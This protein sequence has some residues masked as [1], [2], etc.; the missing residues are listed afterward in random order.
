MLKGVERFWK[1]SITTMSFICYNDRFTPA[2]CA[3]KSYSAKIP[4]IEL[5]ALHQRR[6]GL[7]PAA[8]LFRCLQYRLSP[9][10]A[11][12]LAMFLPRRI[13]LFESPVFL[14]LTKSGIWRPLQSLRPTS[15]KIVVWGIRK[16]S[17]IAASSAKYMIPL[18]MSL[19]SVPD[20]NLVVLT[21]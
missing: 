13:E 12:A 16:I 7:L 10:Q 5:S 8:L 3:A 21:N 9:R 6:V 20:R 18:N 14:A 11:A 4:R 1:V 17:H 2:L 15:L 19:A